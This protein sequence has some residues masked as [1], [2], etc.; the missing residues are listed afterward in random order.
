VAVA[1]GAVR[2]ALAGLA[3]ESGALLLVVEDLDLA[4]EEVS[5]EIE[6]L[7]TIPGLSLLVTGTTL[8]PLPR[9]RQLAL[10]ALTAPEVRTLVGAMLG[11][12][13]VP[14][15]LDAGLVQLTGGLPA[16]VCTALREQVERGAL[17]CEGS[18]PD[19]LPR[20][21]WDPAAKLEPGPDMA[22]RFDRALRGLSD[23]SLCLLR[24]LAA[25]GEVV[26]LDLALRASRSDASGLALGPLVVR[27]LARSELDRGE[28]WIALR[29]AVAGPLILATMTFDERRGAHLALAA[30]ARERGLGD[31]EQRFAVVHAALGA[32]TPEDTERLVEL[33]DHLVGSGRPLAAL[34]ALDRAALLPL[35]SP[36]AGALRALARADGLLA[37]GRLDESREAVNAGRRL[38]DEAR[39]SSLALRATVTSAEL[40]VTAGAQI[41]AAVMAEVA[42]LA[43][44]GS[45]RGHFV[46]AECDRLAAELDR[47][48]VGYERALST[49][50]PPLMDRVAARARFGQA[51]VAEVR[52]DL[53]AAADIYRSLAQELRGRERI[54]EGAEALCRL[55]L[56]RR[57]QG[58]MAA[59]LEA[60]AN[61]ERLV[62]QGVPLRAAHVEVT[63]A[64]ILVALGDHEGAD[65]VLRAS[66]PVGARAPWLLR[67]TWLEVTAELRAA[68]GDSQS[69][70][71]VH[72]DAAAA[73]QAA[74][75]RIRTSWHRGMAALLTADAN[76]A[77]AAVEDLGAAAAH[78][79]QASLLAA[80][81]RIGRDPT[82]LTVAE[83]EARASGDV[84]LLLD[85]L[86][87]M[88]GPG[89]RAEARDLCGRMIESLYGPLRDT[90]LRLPAP[91]WALGEH[92]ARRRDTGL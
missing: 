26:P 66:A 40:L 35:T 49:S 31:W 61:A 41:P 67:A 21:T 30:A 15:G 79:S 48:S 2:V 85:V 9:A 7:R 42:V 5:A 37:V 58:R 39:D 81:A 23:A 82:V 53:A 19:G 45:P 80:G 59:A 65:V 72:L 54:G 84:R 27:G 11:T 14:L 52:G 16:L 73:A 71:A 8:G 1:H 34:E 74:G 92:G 4:E 89:S 60:L 63:R 20:W 83:V 70:L 69:L 90:F 50:G 18:S 10:R 3:A 46:R 75:D 17:W 62:Q 78:R 64:A 57:Q 56:V 44:G 88:R 43:E 38:A 77:A 47:A 91:R 24:T 28:E 13:A 87:A 76:T 32:V 55:A 12:P 33:G 25:A 29:R 22:R 51:A 68:L 86:H 36:R 6:D